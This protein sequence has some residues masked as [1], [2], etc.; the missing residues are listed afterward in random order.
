MTPGS[1]VALPATG[2]KARIWLQY[3]EISNT[4]AL[5]T[6]W[7]FME[8]PAPRMSTG[9]LLRWQISMPFTNSS[10][11]LGVTTPIGIWR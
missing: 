7:P 8:V 3:F 11:F 10:V 1:T 5:L 9:A 6:V 2:S 4:T